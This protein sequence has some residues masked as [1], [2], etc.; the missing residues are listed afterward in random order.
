MYCS[1]EYMHRHFGMGWER[2]LGRVVAGRFHISVLESWQD[3]CSWTCK[4]SGE[5]RRRRWDMGLDCK[6]GSKV[7]VRGGHISGLWN[8]LDSCNWMCCGFEHMRRHFG[9]GWERMDFG[10]RWR[11][12]RRLRL[13]VCY[14]IYWGIKVFLSYDYFELRKVGFIYWKSLVSWIAYTY[15]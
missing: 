10:W 15:H 2:T 13:L 7:V 11:S 12:L 6:S 1:F 5:C 3:S 9:M 14:T 8:C 4:S